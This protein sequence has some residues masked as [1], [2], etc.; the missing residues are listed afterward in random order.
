MAEHIYT[1]CTKSNGLSN[2]NNDRIWSIQATFGQLL[3][4]KSHF[5]YIRFQAYNVRT[6]SEKLPQ[7]IT[8]DSQPR[9][10]I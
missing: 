9:T 8:Y 6:T 5:I 1:T 3:E 10:R 4:D 2:Y 7:K